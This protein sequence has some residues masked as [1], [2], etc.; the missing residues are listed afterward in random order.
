M[1]IGFVDSLPPSGASARGGVTVS[2]G[3]STAPLPAAPAAP[4]QPLPFQVGDAVAEANAAL[5]Q[6][7]QSAVEF[8]YEPDMNMTV[9][10]LVDS[11]SHEVLRQ[12]PSVEMLEIARAIERMQ[13]MLVRGR[14]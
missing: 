2:A 10:K 14:A 3:A 11:S 12:I 1:L 13:L 9:V 6:M 8:E 7:N 4:L 5:K